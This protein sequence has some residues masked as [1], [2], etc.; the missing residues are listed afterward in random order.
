MESLATISLTI[1]C[2]VICGTHPTRVRQFEAA[3]CPAAQWNQGL[4][5]GFDEIL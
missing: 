3:N 4:G 1:S 2:N 5:G